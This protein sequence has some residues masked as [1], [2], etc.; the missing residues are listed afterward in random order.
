MGSAILAGMLR[1]TQRMTRRL[2]TVHLNFMR[3]RCARC[4]GSPGFIIERIS[5][6]EYI[7][8]AVGCTLGSTATEKEMQQTA[9]ETIPLPQ[10]QNTLP[11]R[12]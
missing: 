1:T 9:F 6:I 8:T 11:L 4:Y 3:G 5:V 12:A 2:F 10:R 7:E